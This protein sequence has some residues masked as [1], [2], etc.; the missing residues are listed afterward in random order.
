MYKSSFS[1]K[2]CLQ[3]DIKK[4]ENNVNL[5]IKQVTKL[6]KSVTWLPKFHLLASLSMLHYWFSTISLLLY[7]AENKLRAVLVAFFV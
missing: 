2:K 7:V 5:V 3:I 6:F 1:N 4:L